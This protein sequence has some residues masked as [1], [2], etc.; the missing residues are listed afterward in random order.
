MN[1][2]KAV[3]RAVPV[4]VAGILG[5]LT[6]GEVA[7]YQII[8]DP[9]CLHVDPLNPDDECHGGQWEG[10]TKLGPSWEKYV[11][12]KTL[13]LTPGSSGYT[14]EWRQC[15]RVYEMTKFGEE[16]Q[17]CYGPGYGGSREFQK[18]SCVVGDGSGS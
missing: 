16:T 2:L 14:V 5:T 9:E 11:G 8:D 12:N 10:W 15:R 7:C 13:L 1:A 3:R 17:L 4:I 6:H 18:N